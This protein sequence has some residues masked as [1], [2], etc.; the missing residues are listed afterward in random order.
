[1]DI[2][3]LLTKKA[4]IPPIS[5][6]LAT[7]QVVSTFQVSKVRNWY[8]RNFFQSVTLSA[9][10]S[11]GSQAINIRNVKGLVGQAAQSN[12]PLTTAD[13]KFE[14]LDE[15]MQ[16]LCTQKYGKVEGFTYYRL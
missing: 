1:M 5:V 16:T 7:H 6:E 9:I 10:K 3:I 8:P 14:Y 15:F 2:R 12:T 11:N 4:I 13:I